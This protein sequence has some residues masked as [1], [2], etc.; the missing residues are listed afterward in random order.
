MM[1]IYLYSR[2]FK[3]FVV[4][5]TMIT[6]ITMMMLTGILPAADIR[7]ITRVIP[8]IISVLNFSRKGIPP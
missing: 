8:L 4:D 6:W 1:I 5:V 3:L 2:S 7:H